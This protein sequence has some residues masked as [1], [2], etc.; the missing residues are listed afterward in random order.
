MKNKTL[1]SM[2][3]GLVVSLGVVACGD[4]DEQKEESKVAA[5]VQ[6]KDE[7]M[8]EKAGKKMDNAADKAQEGMKD[9][10]KKM[11]NTMDKA[12][13]GMKDA[14]KKMDKAM[15][16]AKEAMSDKKASESAE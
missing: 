15:D 10:A 14:S 9:A 12:K 1:L 11:D 5:S 2:A 7:G 16:K 13:E 3:L 8:M 6:Q 4:R